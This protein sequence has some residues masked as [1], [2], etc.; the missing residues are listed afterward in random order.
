MPAAEVTY[1]WSPITCSPCVHGGFHSP[2]IHQHEYYCMLSLAGR[3]IPQLL[4]GC[5]GAGTR[6]EERAR[7]KSS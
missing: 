7:N 3:D 4:C 1:L 5:T 2:V 6:Q